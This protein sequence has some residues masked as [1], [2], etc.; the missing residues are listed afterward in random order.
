MKHTKTILSTTA[1]ALGMTGLTSDAGLINEY[2]TGSTSNIGVTASSQINGFNQPLYTL[3]TNL[4]NAEFAPGVLDDPTDGQHGNSTRQAWRANNTTAS[5]AASEWIQWD[6]N[7]SLRLD[8]IRVWNYNDSARY[9]SGI[10]TLDIYL[11]NV[12]VPGDPEGAG[13]LNWTHWAVNATLP[14]APGTSGYTGFDLETVVGSVLPASEFR[15]VRFE[16]N[17]TFIGDGIDLPGGGN[18]GGQ[19]AGLSQIEFFE[20]VPEPGSLAL[21]SIGGLL[22]A[23]RR[24]V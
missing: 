17:S 19:N 20:V 6:L 7:G 8:S 15:F 11:S 23:R 18:L 21:L 3:T 14:G 4:S 5:G 13:A 2:P 10:R 9:E 12:A 24:R 16:V 22:I 1:L